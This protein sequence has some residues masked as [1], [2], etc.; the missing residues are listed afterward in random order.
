MAVGWIRKNREAPA[1]RT[2]RV[3]LAALVALLL[4]AAA[5]PKTRSRVVSDTV[6]LAVRADI[7]GIFPNPPIQ[8]ESFSL[9]VNSNIF[10]G[11]VRLDRNLNPEPAIAERWENPD[12]RTYLFSLRKG[13]RFSNGT[14]LL[15]SD[16]AASLQAAL[17]RPYV[18]RD[19]LQAIE[20]VKA[21][22]TDRVEIRTRSPYPVLL[23]HLA[24]GFVLP[25]SALSQNP[26][27]P[28]GSGPY[29]LERHTPGKELVL[30]ANPYFRGP[31]PVFHRVR[32]VVKPVAAARVQALESGEVQVADNL[33]LGD[34][35]RLG[36]RGG[37]EVIARPGL[38]VLFVAFAMR[39]RPFSDPRVR[40]AIDLA[41][42]R[43]ELIRRA[44][45]G[46]AVRASQ[47]VPPA[48]AGFNPFIAL[49]QTDREKAR[50]M[51]ATAGYANGFSVR[52]DGTNDRYVNDA[53]ILKEIARQ[54]GEVGIR[55]EVN[56]L[57]KSEFFPLLQSQKSSFYL[58]GW[59]CETGDAG[60]ALDAVMHTP[61]RGLLGSYNFQGLSDPE[62]DRLI[63]E[64]NRSPLAA[65]R[66]KLL[67][68]ALAR[69]ATLR[70]I[71]PIEIQTET[72]ALSR[73]VRWDLPLTFAFRVY[74]I[75]PAP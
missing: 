51:L 59:A 11:L 2:R 28:I 13:L 21:L 7:T 1:G 32:F 5:C 37:L 23:Q 25:A 15:A 6:T 3:P 35:E 65:I 16:V 24:R 48:V 41:L 74:E 45:G 20:S 30:V 29:C 44:L 60:D 40:E 4:A 70:P 58:L 68:D 64:S 52:L 18:T 61:T 73:S 49:T 39:E 43:N 26:V 10:E 63:D 72:V 67:A 38:R 54:L 9:D 27:P 55:V 34:I 36:S 22:G 66:S 8:N 71:L 31:M 75:K 47:L 17:E 46:R 62:L 12:E 69:V 19:T 53:E 14:P 33:P 57:P 50:R 42:D 56:A